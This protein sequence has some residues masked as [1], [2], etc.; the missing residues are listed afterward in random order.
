M[1]VAFPCRIS[2]DVFQVANPD[3]N[4]CMKLVSILPS[5]LCV[6]VLYRNT[7]NGGKLNDIPLQ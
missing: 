7:G 1:V 6:P 2:I 5:L 4:N 3:S